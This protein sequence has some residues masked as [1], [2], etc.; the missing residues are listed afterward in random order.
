MISRRKFTCG[1]AAGALAAAAPS[2]GRA[3][4]SGA[5]K[6]LM[7]HD[8]IGLAGLVRAGEVSPRELIEASIQA[9]EALDGEINAIPIRDFE[10]ALDRADS[11]RPQG[12]FAGVPFSIK[13]TANVADLPSPTGGQFYAN[14]VPTQSD[15]LVRL[16]EASGLI[17]LGKSNVP[18]YMLIPSTEG[19]MFGACSNPWSLNHSAGGSSGGAGAAVAAGYMPIAHGTDGGGSIRIPASHCGVFGL[20]PGTDRV[21][22]ANSNPR[23]AFDHVLSRTVRDSALSL[24]VT[25]D[26][27]PDIALPRLGFIDGPSDRRLRIGFY[28]DSYAGSPT[29]EVAQAIMATARLCESLGHEVIEAQQPLDQEEYEAPYI[30]LFGLGIAAT[31]ALIED[32]TGQPV[33]ETGLM[34][35]FQ[36]EFAEAGGDTS[37]EALAEANAFFVNK[38]ETYRNWMMPFD[39]VLSPVMPAPAPELGFL[40]D[41]EID[42]EVMSRR[43]FDYVA[44]TTP[45]NVFGLPA[46]SVPLAMSSDG[47]PIG[48]HFFADYGQEQVLLEIAYELEAARPWKDLWAP[49]SIA[50]L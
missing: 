16:Y 4:P 48:S 28:L 37:P 46:M 26:Q 11:I 50:N 5:T 17:I 27:S 40:F 35:R 2:L 14:R 44:Y 34:N 39:V 30:K 32:A 45:L 23:F 29:P 7:D 47:L 19:S 36:I 1:A 42:Y 8:G 6:M 31:I 38:R 18:E 22:P 33:S 3:E 25:Q 15:G 21:L 43:V 9:I 49:N 41:P 10:R 20:K 24:A 13:D 12:P